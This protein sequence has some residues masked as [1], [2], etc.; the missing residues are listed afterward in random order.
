MT[1][2]A[3]PSRTATPSTIG[4]A[5]AVEQARAEAEVKAAV[6]VAQQCPRDTARARN[7]MIE[8]CEQ[9]ELAQRAFFRYS[10]AGNQITGPS[11]YIARELARCWGN[12]QYGIAEMRRDDAAGESEMMAF[13]WDVET[14]TRS[15]TT[16]IVPHRRDTRNGSVPLVDVR[17]IYENNANMGARRVREAIFAILPPW[18]TEQAKAVC[19]ATIEKGDGTPLPERISGLVAAYERAGIM[20]RQL[21]EK[22]GVRVEN[23]TARDVAALAVVWRS[24]VA[25]ETT[26]EEEFPTAEATAVDPS[27][28]APDRL[29]GALGSQTGSEG[30]PEPS[31]SGAEGEVQ[32]SSVPGSGAVVASSAGPSAPESPLLNTRGGLARTMFAVLNKLGYGG[33]TAEAKAARLAYVSEVI[34]REVGSSTEMTDADAEAVIAAAEK[35]IASRPVCPECKQGKCV[36]CSGQAWDTEADEPTDCRCPDESHKAQA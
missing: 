33:N 8:S 31:V 4:Q 25:R 2:L 9:I 14:N 11:I 5:T 19:N 7:Q 30:P 1:E 13:A 10:R 22:V 3:V 12:V 26:R 17:D 36:N 15:S 27:A 24:L 20:K 21:E 35:E 34:G 6:V 28:P 18:F 29:R 16:F 23:W 32:G